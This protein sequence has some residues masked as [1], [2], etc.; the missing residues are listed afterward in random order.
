LKKIQ[1][2]YHNINGLTKMKI[3]LDKTRKR[4]EETGRMFGPWARTKN[5]NETQFRNFMNGTYVPAP[6]GKVERK[7]YSLLADDDLLVLASP[8]QE[9]AA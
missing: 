5:I 3:D 2:I 8:G 1:K 9:H 4:F 6:G 7:Y